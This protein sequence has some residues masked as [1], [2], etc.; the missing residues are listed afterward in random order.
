M[1]NIVYRP[2]GELKPYPKNARTHSP[3]QVEQIA[4]SITEFGFTNPVLTDDTDGIIAGHGRLM[5]A[6]LLG[7]AEVPTIPLVGLSDEQKRALILADNKLAMTAGWDADLLRIELGEL[8]TMSFDLAVTGFSLGELD[9]IFAQPRAGHGDPDD[10]PDPPAGEPVSTRGTVWVLG[11]HRLCCG[12]STDQDDIDRLMLGDEADLC[13]TSPPYQGQRRYG[14]TDIDDW[15][16]LM[17]GVFA[18]M[19]MRETAQVL[20]NLGLIHRDHEWQPYWDGWIEWMRA[21][22]WRRFGFYVWDQGPGLA[23]D[24][25]GRLAPAHEFIFHFNRAPARVRKTH[26]SKHAG[27]MSKGMLRSGEATYTG[28][29]A[30]GATEIQATK[31]PDSVIR[32]TR[33]KGA[34]GKGIDHPAVFP[35]GLPAELIA[36]YTDPGD[37]VYEPFGGSGT[38]ILAAEQLGRAARAMELQPRYTDVACIRWQRHT[39]R[40]ALRESDGKP[41]DVLAATAVAKAA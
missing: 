30:K 33:H 16:A 24:F 1:L 21:A 2:I 18:H 6:K 28:L 15:D 14:G 5:A 34:L 8:K 9:Q 29:R 36:A 10:L 35:I 4:A 40:Q 25:R 13:V 23:G 12:D 38:T 11:E 39:G 17:Q 32:V 7:L 27:E 19:P 20:V 22:G 26:K 37:V 31:K 3:A 41:F